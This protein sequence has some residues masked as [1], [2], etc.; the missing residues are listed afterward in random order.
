MRKISLEE[1]NKNKG[2]FEILSDNV[3]EFFDEKNT[4]P[5]VFDFAVT[6]NEKTYSNE[7]LDFLI[8]SKKTLKNYLEKIVRIFDKKMDKNNY[9]D[10]NNGITILRIT[11]NDDYE[12]Q[13]VNLNFPNLKPTNFSQEMSIP[14][15]ESVI[16]D[17]KEQKP[18]MKNTMFK[19][20]W[21]EIS[22]ITKANMTLKKINKRI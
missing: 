20:R 2:R 12:Y 16:D 8:V 19:N 1:F 22:T 13:V 5:R 18:E 6:T 4:I 21:E 15:I 3:I 7:N 10:Y 11:L 17:L 14:F 9:I